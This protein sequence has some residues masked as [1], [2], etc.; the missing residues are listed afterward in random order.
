MA[1][2]FEYETSSG[3]KIATAPNIIGFGAGSNA[4]EFTLTPTFTYKLFFA[5]AD[6]SY[7]STGSGTTGDL[8]GTTGKVGDQTRV[9]VETGV[10]F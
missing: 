2:R 1:G 9:M 4:W 10:V 8:F 7:I 3:S 6:F 5:R